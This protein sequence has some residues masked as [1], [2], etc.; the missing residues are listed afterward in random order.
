[1]L[2]RKIAAAIFCVFG[3]RLMG[4]RT[5]ALVDGSRARA[6]L[7]LSALYFSSL[8]GATILPG[9]ITRGTSAR[10]LPAKLLCLA[11]LRWQKR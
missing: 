10:R 3:Y 6:I 5:T 2:Q 9:A 11:E 7:G 4:I 1:M 8:P